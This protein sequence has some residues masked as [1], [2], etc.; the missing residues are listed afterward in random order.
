[1]IYLLIQE[2]HPTEL[3]GRIS[4]KIVGY[5]ED[6]KVAE[7]FKKDVDIFGFTSHT[8]KEVKHFKPKEA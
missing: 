4:S 1:M 8:Y 3:S 6:K 5:T 7:G 2:N